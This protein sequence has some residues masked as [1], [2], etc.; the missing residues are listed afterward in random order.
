MHELMFYCRKCNYIDIKAKTERHV[1][2]DCGSKL[3]S[4]SATEYE[5]G[6]FTAEERCHALD[7]AKN[8][9]FDEFETEKKKDSIDYKTDIKNIKSNNS[10]KKANQINKKRISRWSYIAAILGFFILLAISITIG[11]IS[12]KK[13][14]HTRADEEYQNEY[15]EESADYLELNQASVA[16]TQILGTKIKNASNKK[17]SAVSSK[18][19]I[20]IENIPTKKGLNIKFID[21]GQG[22]SALIECDGHY[23]LVDGGKAKQSDKIYTI[24]RDEG[25][26]YI[27][28]MIATHPDEDHVGGL[29]GALNYATVGACFSPF[30]TC[31]DKKEFNS[32]VKYLSKQNVSITIP[33]ER[34]YFTLGD[35]EITLYDPIKNEEDS[36]NSSIVTRIDYGT[37]SFLLMGDAEEEEENILLSG[38]YDLNVDVIKIGHHGSKYSTG[39]T[40][41]KTVSPEYAVIS[42]GDNSYGHPTEE[43]IDRLTSVESMI[44]RT[45]L[46]GDIMFHSDGENITVE[47]KKNPQTYDVK[48]GSA[49]K[50]G[51]KSADGGALVIPEGTTYVLNINTGRF[52]RTDC[53][54]VKD[55][56]EE[57]REFTTK[58]ADE[59]FEEDYVACKNCCEDLIQSYEQNGVNAGNAVIDESLL[60]IEDS[61][62]DYYE[63]TGAMVWIPASGDKYHSINNCGKM[64]PDKARQMSENEALNKGYEKC[65][66]CWEYL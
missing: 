25:I 65:G 48:A 64:N 42:V 17:S 3:V 15:A 28:V 51:S 24:L 63:D 32:L 19:D 37:T 50:N 41:I 5:W 14:A 13:E 38:G 55:I 26:D 52:H 21:V 39:S 2:K 12:E 7:N 11:S 49:G 58:T 47:T 62:D 20:A 4:L 60:I 35:A 34:E 56:K 23:M 10:K 16:T 61:A 9:D 6:N 53:N 36:N 1:C 43:V 18:N 66:N 40:F 31:P 27:D 46:Q 57:N 45:D 30:E 44:Y 33:G 54:S 29:S 22:D 59:L 8:Y